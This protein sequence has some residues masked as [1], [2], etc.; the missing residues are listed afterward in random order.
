MQKVAFGGW[1]NCYRLAQDNLELIVTGDVGP[2]IIRLGFVGAENEF[3]EFP[4]DLGQTG[5][6]DWR[7]YGGHRFWHSP[8]DPTRTYYPDNE[9]VTVT[10]EAG[11]MRAVQP[12]ETT[13]GIQKELIL[14]H[15]GR[16]QVIVRHRLRNLGLWPVELAPWA[17][18][19]M[20]AGG[21]GIVPQPTAAHPNGLL[22]NRTLVLWPY[23]DMADSRHHWGSRLILLRQDPLAETPTKLGLSANDGWAAYVRGDHLFLKLFDYL[24]G[25]VYPDH[26]CSVEVYT[27]SH[28]LELETLGPLQ[29]LDPGGSIEHLEHWFLFSGAEAGV[30]L[31]SVQGELIDE[32]AIADA[33]LP[34]VAE[35]RSRVGP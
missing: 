20:A 30:E 25:A 34:F 35:A 31:V 1:P 3:A 7:L 9:P 22:P 21:M 2:R 15:V 19:V 27:N 16:N 6:T 26:G 29:C 13:T 4:N 17:L 12:R 33:V 11:T 14:T 5:G 18:S 23:T 10:A 32:D 24:E 28:M 8:E